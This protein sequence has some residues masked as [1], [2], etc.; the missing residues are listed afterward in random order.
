MKPPGHGDNTI[1]NRLMVRV[2]KQRDGATDTIEI[3]ARLDYCAMLDMESPMF[4][5]EDDEEDSSSDEDVRQQILLGDFG[6]DDTGGDKLKELGGDSISKTEKIDDK[7][8][9]LAEILNSG[10][11]NIFSGESLS[12]I[13]K[14]ADQEE[15]DMSELM[16]LDF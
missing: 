10:D 9:I 11:G 16:K 3:Q 12:S 15:A 2:I 8:D 14:H 13:P 6:F 4:G 5:D 1:A 7:P